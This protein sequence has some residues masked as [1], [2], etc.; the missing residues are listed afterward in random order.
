MGPVGLFTDHNTRFVISD[1]YNG[2]KINFNS[3]KKNLNKM[4]LSLLKKQ[5]GN[6]IDINKIDFSNYGNYNINYKYD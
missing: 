6:S 1:S 3:V 5:K 4:N 2:S